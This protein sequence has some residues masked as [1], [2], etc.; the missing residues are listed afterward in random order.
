MDKLKALGICIK[1]VSSHVIDF[2]IITIRP[3]GTRRLSEKDLPLNFE[4]ILDKSKGVVILGR[5][6]AWFSGYLVHEFM[7]NSVP[8]VACYN[9]RDEVVIVVATSSKSQT[10]IGQ[11]I[12]VPFEYVYSS[13]Y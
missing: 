6:I 1:S 10:K 3:P 12:D 4:P 5:Q 11:I 13:K 2:Q 8:W 7:L 9:P